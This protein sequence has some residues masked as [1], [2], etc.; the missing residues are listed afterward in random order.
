MPATRYLAVE[1]SAA[2][3]ADGSTTVPRPA[4]PKL[5]ERRPDEV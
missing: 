5:S 3:K 1:W 2:P 4:A